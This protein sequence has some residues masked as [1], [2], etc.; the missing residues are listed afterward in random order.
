MIR[1]WG[2]MLLLVLVVLSQTACPRNA[3]KQNL[4]SNVDT[5]GPTRE[6]GGYERR[7]DEAPVGEG[8]TGASGSHGVINQ[9]IT[10]MRCVGNKCYMKGT[11][12][13]FLDPTEA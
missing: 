12:P 3:A 5:P 9:S 2:R 6:R 11:R 7:H 1:Q 8:V 4:D 10:P 13:C